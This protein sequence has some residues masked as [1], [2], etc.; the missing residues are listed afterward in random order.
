MSQETVE[1]VRSF[2]ERGEHS[3]NIPMEAA[4]VWWNPRP[5][6]P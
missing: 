1:V 3:T 2:Y 5:C 4:D 6:N